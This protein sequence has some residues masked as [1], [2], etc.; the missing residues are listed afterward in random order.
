MPAHQEEHM[1][2]PRI[3]HAVIQ[4]RALQAVL[5]G[6]AGT[7]EFVAVVPPLKVPGGTGS[8]VRIFALVQREH[9]HR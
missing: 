5:A 8:A 1:S 3:S 6:V 7:Y 4:R 2:D 9:D